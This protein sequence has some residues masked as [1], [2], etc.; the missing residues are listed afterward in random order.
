MR[1][2]A[3]I[4]VGTR[5]VQID[6]NRLDQYRI[7]EKPLL[8]SRG[9][10]F[11]R[12]VGHIVLQNYHSL[13]AH[14]SVPIIGPFLDML[15]HDGEI[16]SLQAVVLV[17][18]DQA[19]SLGDHH[20][21]DTVNYA[22]VIERWLLD[23]YPSLDTFIK[24]VQGGV[25]N[26]DK[27]YAEW[28]GVMDRPPFSNL[29]DYNKVYL[30][31]QGG[32]GAINTALM[33]HAI[34]KYGE[35]VEVVGV[36]ERYGTAARLDFARNFLRDQNKRLVENLLTHHNYAAA[37]ELSAVMPEVQSLAVVQQSRLAFDFGK[38]RHYAA[39]L[40]QDD[41]LKDQLIEFLKLV[42]RD[43]WEKLREVY[44]NAKVMLAR[45][46][47]VDF[48]IR[49]FRLVEGV[50]MYKS[51]AFLDAS[52]NKETWEADFERLLNNPKNSKLKADLERK[53]VRLEGLPSTFTW[54]QMWRSFAEKSTE[55]KLFA[56]LQNLSSYRNATIGAH[57]FEGTS[58]QQLEDELNRNSLSL[59]SV[60]ERL[61]QFFQVQETDPMGFE[62]IQSRII[63]LVK[64][65]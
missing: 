21:H 60:V 18:T 37:A 34:N 12:L 48:L 2:A 9:K 36:N 26:I 62:S 1:T 17:A 20:R 27:Q 22:K 5:D 30:F 41:D 53:K 10:P 28:I 58:K 16:A 44:R 35:R 3:I 23:K 47:Y 42:E 49:C 33:L 25:A 19:E 57:G 52:F 61:D 8:D 13:K 54:L 40:R 45:Q 55:R 50:A 64:A 38:A 24:P 6:L 29:L 31:N 65:T 59:T 46:Q 4:T 51:L 14:L 11:G 7:D 32:I 15:K 39:K 43:E 63:T 56:K